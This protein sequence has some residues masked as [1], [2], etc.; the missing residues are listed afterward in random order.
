LVIQPVTERQARLARAA[1][2]DFGKGSGHPAGLNFG[3]A[4]EH[5]RGP[6]VRNFGDE[7]TEFILKQMG[8]TYDGASPRHSE[9]VVT[10][11]ILEHLPRHSWAG[12]VCGVDHGLGCAFEGDL[13]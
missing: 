7:I 12:T 10:G 13:S 6:R 3:D 5:L 11:S 8:I 1:H 2:A 9:L 4:A